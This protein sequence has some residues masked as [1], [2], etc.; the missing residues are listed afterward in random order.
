MDG[1]SQNVSWGT[2][3]KPLT[4]FAGCLVTAVLAVH[5]AIAH[6]ILRHA[7]VVATA[8]LVVLATWK[9]AVGAGSRTEE[10]EQLRKANIG[11]AAAASTAGAR[12]SSAGIFEG[13]PAERCT[14]RASRLCSLPQSCSSLQSPQSLTR[15]HT[16]SFGLH[17]VLVQENCSFLHSE[18]KRRN[19]FDDHSKKNKQKK[20]QLRLS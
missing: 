12:R 6:Y 16:H 19:I 17:K 10:E 3:G 11:W 7:H 5:L 20:K 8:E 1:F 2:V 4:D 9:V 15:S 18:N 13:T 14:V